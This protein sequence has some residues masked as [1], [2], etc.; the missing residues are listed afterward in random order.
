MR[1]VGLIAGG[2]IG[3]VVAMS[4][5]GFGPNVWLV[6]AVC[7]LIGVA[8][9]FGY[10][11]AESAIGSPEASV[12]LAPP[13]AVG[14][15]RRVMRLRS[16]LAYVHRNGS[17]FEQLHASLVDLIDDQLRSVHH[18]DRI[19]D[20][21]A[22]RAVIGNDLSTFVENDQTANELARP[23]HLDHILTLIEQI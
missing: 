2:T 21:D 16:G 23:R 20:P 7:V 4:V 8:I 19:A 22:A 18:I 11:L 9:W 14:S 5:A 10:D 1:P 15:D 6:G 3:V 12:E 13:S 17:S